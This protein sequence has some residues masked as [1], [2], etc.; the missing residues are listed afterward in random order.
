MR[1]TRTI[2]SHRTARRNAH[3][4]LGQKIDLRYPQACTIARDLSQRGVHLVVLDQQIDTST[5]SGELHF[6]MLGAIAQFENRLQYER[7]MEGIAAA[8]ARGVRFGRQQA[9]TPAQV[10]EVQQRRAQG[11]LIKTLMQDY[12]LS[13]AA[14]YRYLAQAPTVDAQAAD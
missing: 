2:S 4:L 10:V 6:H 11:V 3:G 14:L 7:Q 9:L 1:Q 13:K 12:H 8:K 5:P